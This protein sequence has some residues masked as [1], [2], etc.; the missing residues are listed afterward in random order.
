MTKRNKADGKIDIRA[1]LEAPV[2]LKQGGET[3]SMPPYEATLRQHVKKAL[4]DP[5]LPSIKFV[6][7][8]AEKHAVIERPKTKEHGGV[9]VVPK[10]LPDE[11]QREIFAYAPPAG[12]RDDMRRIFAIIRKWIKILKKEVKSNEQK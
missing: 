11:A 12:E 6:I 10:W 1:A 2:R 9:F 4:V 8:E 5:S 3:K 7:G